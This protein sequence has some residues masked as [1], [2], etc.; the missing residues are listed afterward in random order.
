M[1]A[2]PPVH[3]SPT[4]SEPAW[5]SQRLIALRGATSVE[6]N[7]REAILSRT[8]ELLEQLMERN[9]L[10]TTDLV[11]A[12][13]TVTADLNAEFPAVAARQIGFDQVPLLC[14]QEI[15]VPGSLP[16]AVRILLHTYA[17]ADHKARHVYL[18]EARVLRA[19]LEAAQ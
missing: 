6:A 15:P 18:H 2:V 4:P 5:A 13:F 14:T 1:R 9:G 12:I 17:P 16:L 11:S 8:A 7:E 10:E 3:E 19:D